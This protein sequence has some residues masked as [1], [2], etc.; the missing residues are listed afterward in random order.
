MT[1]PD[2]TSVRAGGQKIS[3]FLW[4][5]DRMEEAVRFYVSIFPNSRIEGDSG[6]EGEPQHKVMTMSFVLDGVQFMALAGGPQFK[7]NEAISFF[8]KCRDQA[9]VDRYWT[10]LTAD[11]GEEGQCG[12]CKDRFGLSWQVVPDALGQLMGDP[13]PA[14]SQRVLQAML[15][16]RKIDVAGLE[17]AHAG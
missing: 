2:D 13:D 10:A 6:S 5:D 14:R 15:Q 17:A 4:F 16:M 11:G 8:V 12:W 7:F 9:D 3:P 1:Y